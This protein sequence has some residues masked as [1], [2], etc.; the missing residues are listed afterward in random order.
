MDRHMTNLDLLSNQDFDQK[1]AVSHQKFLESLNNN[2]YEILNLIKL[3]V[4]IDNKLEEITSFKIV[5]FN[6]DSFDLNLVFETDEKSSTVIKSNFLN[7]KAACSEDADKNFNKYKISKYYLLPV[8]F[9]VKLRNFDDY[10][11]Y[12]MAKLKDNIIDKIIFDY[13][14][15]EWTYVD[16]VYYAYRLHMEKVRLIPTNEKI[17][18]VNKLLSK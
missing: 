7:S 4:K 3:N 1:I 5:S 2:D 8:D 9:E 11:T 10:K 12:L 16:T 15:H 14:K 6:F 13:Y 18:I 17:A